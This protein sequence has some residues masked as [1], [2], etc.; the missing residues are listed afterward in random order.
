[1]SDAFTEV[2][3]KSHVFLKNKKEIKKLYDDNRLHKL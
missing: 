2:E 1:M 3:H